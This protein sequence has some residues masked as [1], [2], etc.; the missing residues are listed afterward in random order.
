MKKNIEKIIEIPENVKVEFK[1]SLFTVK[2]GNKEA[3]RKFTA[4]KV[5]IKMEGNKIK[6][7]AKNATRK[8][9]KIIGTLVAHIKNMINGMDNEYIYRLEICNI[10]FPMNVK[11]EKEKVLI[12]NFL[13][14]KLDRV[15]RIMPNTSVKLDGNEITVTSFDVES[16]GQTALNIESA[17]R[18]RNR[19]KRIFQ[20]GI[21]ITEKPG[22]VI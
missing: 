19:D 3:K 1:N 17:T 8:E 14:E 22:R 16:A 4:R 21:F 15:A 13:G 18:I 11:I 6:V 10:H 12:K 2:V 7:F 9:A 5:D 20:D